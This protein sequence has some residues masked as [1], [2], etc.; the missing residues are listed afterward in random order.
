VYWY[1]LRN[2][3]NVVHQCTVQCVVLLIISNTT[4]LYLIQCNSIWYNTIWLLDTNQYHNFDA[5]QFKYILIQFDRTVFDTILYNYWILYNASIFD[6][7]QYNTTVLYNRMQMYFIQYDTN[8]FHTIRYNCILYNAI[9][10]YFRQFNCFWHCPLSQGSH[11]HCARR[12]IHRTDQ[13]EPMFPLIF[14]VCWQNWWLS[15][16]PH[17]W[18]RNTSSFS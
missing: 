2:C 4:Q 5:T 10:L 9:Q 12:N 17:F 11:N 1:V 14:F 18:V 3:L 13:L 15:E 16:Q 8:L 7:I 6:T